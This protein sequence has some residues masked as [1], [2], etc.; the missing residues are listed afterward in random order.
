MPNPSGVLSTL[1]PDLAGS[2]MEF[3]LEANQQ[4]FIGLE[5][6]PMFTTSVQADSVGRIPLK[7]LLEEGNTERASGAGYQRGNWTFEAWS[8]AT[9]EHGWEEPVD[10]REARIYGSYFNAEQVATMRARNFVLQNHEKRVAAK[11]FNAGVYTPS[12]VTT[13]WSD[14]EN[15]TPIEDVKAKR[16]LFW[17]KIG[18]LPDALVINWK[19]F[20]NLRMN[21]SIIDRVKYTQRA[22]TVDLN[23][24]LIA[25]ALGVPRLIVARAARNSANVGQNAVLTDV[26]SSSYGALIKLPANLADIK[27][28]CW[29]RTFMY[30]GDGG[31][32]VESYRDEKVRSNI[33]RHRMDTDEKVM[34][35][36]AALLIGNVTA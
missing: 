5:V 1:R 30:T 4:G 36:D 24:Q 3:D 20:E 8:F 14:V 26:W 29:G 27:S 13:A 33:I 18:S 32:V 23:E 6:M 21:A 25:D 34:Y 28:P 15:S 11:L 10:D 16:E 35:E 9:Q 12:N 22:T 19:V 17:G 2:L 7:Q 31:A